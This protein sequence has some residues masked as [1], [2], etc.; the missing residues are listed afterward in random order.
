MRSGRTSSGGAE[1]GADLHHH[2]VLAY[3]A[4]LHMAADFLDLEPADVGDGPRRGGNRVV[5]RV[6]DG[7]V[8]RPD[9]FDFL[10]DAVRH[11]GFLCAATTGGRATHRQMAGGYTVINTNLDATKP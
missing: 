7:G 11:C 6:G 2:L 10:K 9:E 4:A 1:A 8:R 5:D 3:L